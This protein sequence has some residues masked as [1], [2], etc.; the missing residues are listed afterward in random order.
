MDRE[1][2]TTEDECICVWLLLLSVCTRIIATY[3]VLLM[4]LLVVPPR[5][6]TNRGSCC[7]A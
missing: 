4:Y 3:L 5:S 2:R 7:D 1:R 6:P